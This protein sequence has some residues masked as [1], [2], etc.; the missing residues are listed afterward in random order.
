MVTSAKILY[1]DKYVHHLTSFTGGSLGRY[2]Q[3]KLAEEDL[4]QGDY[5]QV[6]ESLRSAVAIC[7]RWVGVCETLTT[8]FWKNYRPNPWKG[9]RFT[10]ENLKKLAQRLEQVGCI[11]A[12]C[13]ESQGQ[14][15]LALFEKMGQL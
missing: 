1:S 5:G 10:P 7:E 14:K 11:I 12:G 4:W 6:K 3:R 9:E 15:F 2:V 8:Q 13:A